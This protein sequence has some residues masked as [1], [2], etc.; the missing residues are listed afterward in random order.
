MTARGGQGVAV[1][2]DHS[3][4]QQVEHLFERIAN[5][6]GRL[7]LLVNNV[8]AGP[9]DIVPELP[10]WERPMSDW[11]VSIDVALRAHFVASVLAARTMVPRG[12]GVIANIS[13]FASRNPMFSVPYGIAKAGADKMARHMAAQLSDTGVIALC[14]WLG[15]VRTERVMSSGVD[16]IEGFDLSTFES[17]EFG[18][19]ILAA[20]ADDPDRVRYNGQVLIAAEVA[21]AYDVVD[22]NGS[23]PP[24][25]RHILG[26]PE[27]S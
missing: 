11:E 21:V 20:I 22:V 26:S 5:E 17:T 13:S 16:S 1:V 12:S 7:D 3:V 14:L 10:F 27:L 19:H 8:F 25:L 9:Y 2:C 15:P 23:S 18:G 6:Q 24:S 4:D